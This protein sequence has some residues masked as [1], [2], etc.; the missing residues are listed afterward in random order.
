MS[1]PNRVMISISEKAFKELDNTSGI[2]G[3]SV[4]NFVETLATM[5]TLAPG[6][7]GLIS[8]RQ[9]M[10]ETPLQWYH[11]RQNIRNI[12]NGKPL[13]LLR[14]KA[15]SHPTMRP[16]LIIANGPSL[17]KEKLE[18]IKNFDF[19]R[20]GGMIFCVDSAA[21]KVLEAGVYPH[22]I[23]HLD[24]RIY[25]REFF[26][27]VMA[28]DLNRRLNYIAPIDMHPEVVELM[29]GE[30]YWYNI[31]GPDFP[32]MNKNPYL[33]FMFPEIPTMDS[34]GNVGVFTILLANYL[35]CNPIGIVGLDLSY[36]EGTKPEDTENYY[37]DVLDSGGQPV[38][39]ED[40]LV[41]DIIWPC[42][43]SRCP[44]ESIFKGECKY[45]ETRDRKDQMCAQEMRKQYAVVKDIFGNNRMVDKIFDM[46]LEILE[47]RIKYMKKKNPDLLMFNCS[48]EGLAYCKGLEA[49]GLKE[50]FET[51]CTKRLVTVPTE[52]Q[53][54]ML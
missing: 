47:S 16:C 46:Y 24:N 44:N 8:Y 53:G 35:N 32:A 38:F 41:K 40:G 1:E 9:A 18:M 54:N 45:H 43:E 4:N 13:K 33:Q 30:I 26:K 25:A 7:S 5:C 50:Y 19:Q 17:T 52:D 49:V 15:R 21:R 20:L 34:A 14:D 10:N 37:L 51:W 12:L 11:I 36:R 2:L 28:S 22:F 29:R 27:G 48:G 3:V 6:E 39:G 42:E 31:A 23:V